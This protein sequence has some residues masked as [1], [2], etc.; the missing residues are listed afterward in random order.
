MRRSISSCPPG[1][2]YYAVHMTELDAEIFATR[3]G[4]VAGT[5][6]LRADAYDADLFA[7]LVRYQI[8]MKERVARESWVDE[9]LH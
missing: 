8:R 6:Y 5:M 2:R 9:T 4:R 7:A 1:V 3:V